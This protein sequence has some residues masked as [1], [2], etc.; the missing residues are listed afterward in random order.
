[1]FQVLTC[2]IRFRSGIT[3][4]CRW[5]WR[6]KLPCNGKRRCLRSR[7]KLAHYNILEKFPYE[8]SGR[9]E[10]ESGCCESAVITKPEII[11]AD[12][13][14]G[15]LIQNPQT[16]FCIFYGNKS[17]RPDHFNGHTFRETA[18][19]ANRI[20]FLKDGEVYHQIYRGNETNEG[21][22]AKISGT[23]TILAQGGEIYA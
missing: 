8:I 19:S 15:A 18:S 7:K 5:F 23:L 9:P 13:P 3:F 4:I 14:T 10:T 1:M 2:W 17:L 12:E 11:L 22:F 6:A 20:L 16:L 21:L